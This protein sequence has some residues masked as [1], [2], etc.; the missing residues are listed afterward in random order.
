MTIPP[1]NVETGL[2]MNEYTYK[3]L[4]H[5]RFLHKIH[6]ALALSAF[7]MLIPSMLWTFCEQNLIKSWCSGICATVTKFHTQ[8]ILH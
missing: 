4:L 5:Y 2:G 6:F 8:L 3:I 1:K 7:A